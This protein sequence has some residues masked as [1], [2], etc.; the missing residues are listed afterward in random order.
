M[1]FSPATILTGALFFQSLSN[2]FLFWYL[3]LVEITWLEKKCDKFHSE[4]LIPLLPVTRDFRFYQAIRE[5]S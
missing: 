4:L 2:H 5:R 3:H 1:L